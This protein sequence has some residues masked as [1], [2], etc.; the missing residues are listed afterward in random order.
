MGQLAA[1]DEVFAPDGTPTRVVATTPVWHDRPCYRIRFSDGAAVVADAEHLWLTE[2]LRAR[3]T[4]AKLIRR[5]ATT[6]KHGTDQRHKRMHYPQVVT[7][8]HIAETVRARG[9]VA[10]HSVQATAPLQYPAQELPIDPYLLGAWL[11]DGS[12]R[13]AQLTCADPE[14]IDRIRAAGQPCRRQDSTPYGWLLTDGVRSR[15]KPTSLTSRLAALGLLSDKHIPA[16]YLRGS[17]PQRLALLQGLMDTDGTV[18]EQ[19]RGAV[20]CE[21]SVC[22]ERLARH[23]LGLLHGL[24]VK[25][26]LRSGPAKLNGRVVG[27]RY[28]LAFQTDLPVFHLPRK[29]A[30]LAP[31]RTRRAKLRYIVA[32]EPVAS[33]PVRCIQVERKDGMYVA[34]R[35]CIPTHNSM[36]GRQ[37]AVAAAAGLHPF[38]R[39]SYAPKRV[40]F[41]DCEN[42]ERQGRRRF[43]NLERIAR[44]KGQRVPDGGMHL[45][46]RP[47]GIDLTTADDAAWLLERVTAHR[48]DLLYIGSFYR[49]HMADTNDEPAARRVVQVLDQARTKVDCALMVEAHS[50]HGSS[51]HERS[52]R[53]VGSSLLLRWPEYG[54]GITP[55]P[56]AE[57]GPDD[58]CREVLVKPWRGAR[59][60]VRWPKELIWSV[61][62]GDWPWVDPAVALVPAWHPQDA[63]EDAS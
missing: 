51:G 32:V 38:S 60:E 3:E 27:T 13:G 23:V 52:V 15:Y 10:N 58:R 34:G 9:S 16:S 6:A 56:N 50:P 46:H 22:L 21:F 36:I 57:V 33:V 8:R 62:D 49:L 42:S 30:R 54:Y 55:N 26:T 2:T 28:R 19:A 29:A 11:G 31:L 63:R 25:V 40:L 4:A 47:S 53:P 5:P 43:R 39:G 1:G 61:V 17:V 59:D 20:V 24:G 18:Q 37:I 14:I 45:I 44:L 48:P 12:S 7:T 41:I 35:E